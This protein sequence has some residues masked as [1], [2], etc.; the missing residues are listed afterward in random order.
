MKCTIAALICVI[1]ISLAIICA[2]C[3]SQD[4]SKTSPTTSSSLPVKTTTGSTAGTS[5]GG[6]QI[7]DTVDIEYTGTLENGTVFDSSKDRGP[8]SFTLG[9]GTAILGFD[10]QIQG[11]KIGES[12]KFTLTPDEAYGYYNESKI[13]QFP[14]SFIPEEERANVTIGQ[15]VTLFNGKELVQASVKSLNSTNVTFDFNSPMA[16]KSLTFDVKLVNLT[17]GTV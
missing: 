16:G 11:M 15:T 12:K 3:T 2:G 4:T 6:A 1:F 10:K 17:P 13:R 5:T 14:I 7:G 9:D 8:F